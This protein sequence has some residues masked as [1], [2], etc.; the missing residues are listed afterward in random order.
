VL[1]DAG[2]ASKIL[3]KQ[4]VTKWV[5]YAAKVDRW[6]K[7]EKVQEVTISARSGV[8]GWMS[9]AISDMAFH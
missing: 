5:N 3:I 9:N 2:D 8:D 6:M 7:E 1:R 4:M